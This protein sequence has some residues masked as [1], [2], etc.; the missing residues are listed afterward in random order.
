M[1]RAETTERHGV[2][3]AELEHESDQH[4]ARNCQVEL[5]EVKE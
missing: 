5:L 2:G 1:T 3:E 4:Q